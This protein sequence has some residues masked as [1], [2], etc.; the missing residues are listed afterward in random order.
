M[1]IKRLTIELDDSPDR[2]GPTA[3]P[4]GVRATGATEFKA[5]EMTR[6][7]SKKESEETQSPEGGKVNP[8]APGRTISDLVAEYVNEPRVMATLLIFAPFP[9]FAARIQMFSDLLYPAAVGVL[10]NVVWFGIPWAK[11]LWSTQ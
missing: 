10:L 6:I 5:Q 4:E 1:A 11:R 9:F 2:A 3:I 7:P 8:R